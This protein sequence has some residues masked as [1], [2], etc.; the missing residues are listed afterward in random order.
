[1]NTTVVVR[2]AV[3]GAPLPQTFDYLWPFDRPASVGAR[4]W[5]PFGRRAAAAI[6]LALADESSIDPARLKPVRRSPDDVPPVAAATLAL[7]EFTAGYYQHPIGQVLAVALPACYRA[8]DK[9]YKPVSDPWFALTP[10]GLAAL[11]GLPARAKV[12][13][14][15][16]SAL[17]DGPAPLSALRL[18]HRDARRV[19][20]EAAAAGWVGPAQPTAALPPHCLRIPTAAQAAAL[21]TLPDPSDGFSTHLLHGVTGSGKSEIYLHLVARALAAGRQALLLVPEIN[22]TPQLERHVRNAFPGRALVALHSALAEGERDRGWLDAQAGAADIVLGTRLAVFVPLPRLGLIIVD[23]EHDASYKQQ[24]GLRYSARD[25]A[26]YRGKIAQAPVVLGS[27]TPSLESYQACRNGRYQRVVVSERANPAARLPDIRLIDLRREAQVDG[28]AEP[29]IV[30]LRERVARGEQSLVFINRRGYAPVL[31]CPVCQWASGC[32]RCSA[33]MTLHLARKRLACHHCGLET[34]IP[35]SCPQCGNVDLR[36]VG[37]GTQRIEQSLAQWLPTARIARVDRDSTR[38]KDAWSTLLTQIHAGQLDVLVGTQMLA[39]GH[40]FPALTLVGVL[41]A[42]SGLYSADFRAAERL[43]AQLMQVAGRAG[44]AGLAGEVLIQTQFPDHPLFAALARHDYDGYADQLLRERQV[45]GF[46]PHLHQAVLRAE[47]PTLEEA[48]TWLQQAAQ[49]AREVDA[50]I[51]VYDP[52]PARMERIAGRARAQ[53]LVQHTQRPRLQ[54]F[55]SGWT[56][57]LRSRRGKVGRWL[58][59]VDPL[60]V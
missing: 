52:V 57:A 23:E 12:R 56:K 33:R 13:R 1:M 53:L 43:F 58:L 25:L 19:L 55:L 20:D 41:N 51:D 40:D 26:V 18:V 6:V 42:D 22:L 29:L 24:E 15:L 27:A 59:D 44:R 2:V 16:L 31:M 4:V 10:V 5:V 46:P 34:A 9:A 47:S 28:V 32:V 8:T 17:S 3:L 38:R 37:Q 35:H 39:K 54:A 60:E 36:P 50:E 30:A 45:A 49:L 11:A 21:A 7:A 14:L 48:V